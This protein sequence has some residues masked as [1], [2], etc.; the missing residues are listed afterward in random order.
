MPE[1]LLVLNGGDE[2]N[3]GNEPQDRELVAARGPGPAYVL[4]TAA[5]RGGPEQAARNAQ[6][7]FGRLGLELEVLPVLTRTDAQKPALAELARSAGAFYLVGGDPGHAVN[8]LQGS[9]V[10]AAMV[11][12]WEAGAALA[13]S[14][15]GAMALCQWTLVMAR[16]PKHDIRRAKPA[17]GLVPEV[18]LLPH[19]DTF[20]HRWAESEIVDRPE[21]LFFLGPDERSAAVWSAAAGW[22]ALGR[23]GVAAG[24]AGSLRRL[25]AGEPIEGLPRPSA[26]EARR[27]PA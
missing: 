22:R 1:G 4:P 24:P 14:S 13:G 26:E 6:R 16:W 18:T 5:A 20:G 8:A 3:P 2:F 12:A 17:L 9:A 25:A 7:W 11:D 23:G 27:Q 19:Y 21:R 10:W 15:A